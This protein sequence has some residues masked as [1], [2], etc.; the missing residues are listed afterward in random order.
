MLAGAAQ[1]EDHG[2]TH[3]ARRS[4]GC[5]AR[6]LAAGARTHAVPL[7]STTSLNML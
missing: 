2:A 3:D 5:S 1:I 6:G 4:L 7:H